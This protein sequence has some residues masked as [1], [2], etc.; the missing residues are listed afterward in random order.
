MLIDNLHRI[1][2]SQIDQIR[3]EMGSGDGKYDIWSTT[4][5]PA[6]WSDTARE[7]M[8]TPQFDN[9]N[10]NPQLQ[11]VSLMSSS[12]GGT[13]S[14]G[15]PSESINGCLF[16]EKADEAGMVVLVLSAAFA[17]SSICKHFVGLFPCFL[18]AFLRCECSLIVRLCAVVL[19]GA[20][21]ADHP[22]RLREVQHAW[23][24]DDTHRE[25][26][27][28]GKCP[29]RVRSANKLDL[30]VFASCACLGFVG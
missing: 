27:S 29:K 20:P 11:R 3:E 19:R 6:L 28:R 17:S 24:D 26:G 15:S 9:P 1:F 7:K 21:K 5:A 30:M 2:Y 13:A 10:Q 23:L 22:S 18:R 12:S 14:S 4:D 25:Q 8:V 16:Q